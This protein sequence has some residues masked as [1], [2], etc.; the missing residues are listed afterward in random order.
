MRFGPGA[1]LALATLLLLQTQCGRLGYDEIANK[2]PGGVGGTVAD[3]G[4]TGSGGLSGGGGT[5]G[6][7]GISGAGGG[8]FGGGGSGAV[9]GAG[10]VTSGSGGTAGNGSGGTAGNGSGGTAPPDG[11]ATDGTATDGPG[12]CQTGSVVRSWSFDAG[13]ESWELSGQGTMIWNGAMGD[14][15]AGALQ[16]DL[17]NGPATHPRIVQPLGNLQ[18]R[19]I[20]ARVWV[21]SGTGVTIKVFVQTGVR[22]VWA[23]GGI[24]SPALGQWTCVSLNIDNPVASTQQYD[25]T[26][27]QILGFE[28]QASSSAR[29]YVDQVTY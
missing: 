29:I 3:G 19:T 1:G 25:P 20:T 17:A 24:F 27:V 2:L 22:L 13:V 6:G 15:S 23:D 21:D 10:G 16:L 12:G 5:N 7:G 9:T 18:G 26:N 11:G 4:V 14:P 8:A 28:V